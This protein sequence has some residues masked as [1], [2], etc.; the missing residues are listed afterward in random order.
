MELDDGRAF[1]LSRKVVEEAGFKAGM[2]LT[3]ERFEQL[4]ATGWLR[5]ALDASLR[6]I[7]FRPRSEAEVRSYLSRKRC[8][9]EVAERVVVRLRERKELDDVAFTR[10][11]LENRDAFRP[12]SRRLLRGELRQKGI[13]AGLAEKMVQ[14][15]DDEAAA[16]RLGR[17]RASRLAYLEWPEFR[18]KLAG[19]LRRRDFDYETI[20]RVAR[21]LW[22][23]R[24]DDEPS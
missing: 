1:D 3:A 20:D 9:L 7:A 19:Y 18:L 6:F 12:R 14:G 15:V 8:P 23:E 17:L 4:L 11:W 2:Q 21:A 5:D 22:A 13:P 24:K 16:F 10:F